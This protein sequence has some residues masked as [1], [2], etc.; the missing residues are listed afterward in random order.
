MRA[1]SMDL[2]ERIVEAVLDGNE[3]MSRIAK[4]FGVSQKTVEKFKY[5]WRDLGTIE[6][7]THKAGRK[8]AFSDKQRQNLKQLVGDNPGIT[9]EELRSKLRMKCSLTTIWNELRRLGYTHKKN[10]YKLVS[11]NART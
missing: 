3:S 11:S 4:R 7:Q 2:R 8:P 5:Q 9:L 1:L 10:S 6:P